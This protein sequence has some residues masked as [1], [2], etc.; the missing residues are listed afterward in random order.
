[1]QSRI[2]S[3]TRQLSEYFPK[4]LPAACALC[5]ADCEEPLCASCYQQYF[6][7]QTKR[8]AQCATPFYDV[9]AQMGMVC[10]AC[11]NEPPSF[12]ATIVVVDYSPPIDQLVLALKFGGKLTLAPM[13]GHIL[14]TAMLTAQSDHSSSAAPVYSLPTLL[15]CVPLGSKRLAERGFNQSLEIARPLA[16]GLGITLAPALLLRHRETQ[17]QTLL[18]PKE[19]K[20]NIR[21]AFTVASNALEHVVGKHIGV[22]DDVMT[23]G[24][25]LNEIARTLKRFSAERVT[26]LVFARTPPH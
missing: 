8:C 25:T 15:T 20:K 21:N 1:M 2:L 12:D 23:T 14:R 16:K 11:L 26:N 17:A 9:H 5:T 10:G 6:S 18:H 19:R 3:W 4:L 24:E 7:T 22:V 13:F